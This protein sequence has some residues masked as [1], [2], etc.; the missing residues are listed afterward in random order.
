MI[1]P[2]CSVKLT[3]YIQKIT[4][5]LDAFIKKD[6]I[7]SLSFSKLFTDA[8][9]AHPAPQEPD[10]EKGTVDGNISNQIKSGH[11]VFSDETFN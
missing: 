1:W 6:F 4:N 3:D 8:V 10:Q 5:V 2:L 11:I 9:A 7:L